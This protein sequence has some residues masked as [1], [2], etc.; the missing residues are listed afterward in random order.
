MLSLPILKG[1]IGQWIIALSEFELTYQ[2]AKAIK[3]QVMDD[4]VTQHCGPEVAIVEPNP[5]TMFFD[6]SL[7]GVGT[8]IGIILIS[9]QRTN[10][11]FAIPIEK[12]STNNQAEYQAVLKGIKPL[13]EINAEVVEIF[14]DSQL[15]I[16]QLAGEYE[17]KDDILRIYHEKCLQLLQE[18]KIV[19]LE[20]IP[21]CH[22]SEAN[23]LAQGAS[24]YRLILT[25]ELPTED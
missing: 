15:V 8:G 24:G 13:R 12:T 4:L 18:F 9:P 10:Y 3:G 1:K 14:G 22:N 17:C 6:G 2:S 5:L 21:K 19:N 20:H 16:N 11:E 23:R 25:M 7:C